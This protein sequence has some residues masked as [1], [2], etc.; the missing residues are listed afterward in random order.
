MK[1]EICHEADAE[2]V[3]KTKIAGVEKE[4]YVCKACA[5]K[6]KSKAKA[7]AEAE[8]E[9]KGEGGKP[10]IS[11]VGGKDEPPPPFVEDLVKATLGFMKGVAEA[12]QNV[13]RKC[14]GCKSNWET[15]KSSGRL[16][17]PACWKTFAQQIQAEF[18]RDAYGPR[19]LGAVPALTTARAT[20][21]QRAIL[22]RQLKAAIRREDYHE[23]ARIQ[24]QID[25]LA[26]TEAT[27]DA[28]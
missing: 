2:T 15:I 19:H 25:A 24:K 20:D 1:C 9:V 6:A 17:C 18:L 8:A 21:D 13:N 7:E 26:S 11:V 10:H 4:L 5:A 22:A 27:G 3:L 16:G 28:S 23:A 14:P 12:E